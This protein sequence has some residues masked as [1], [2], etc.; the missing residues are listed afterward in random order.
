M[1]DGHIFHFPGGEILAGIAAWWFVS[2]SYY[3]Y[4]DKNHLNWRNVKTVESRRKAYNMSKIYHAYWLRE[5]LEMRNLDVHRNKGN[6]SSERIKVMAQKVL[7]VISKD[8]GESEMRVLYDKLCAG[9]AEPK[10]RR[11]G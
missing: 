7:D 4:I 3:L 1:K 10:A 8:N 5:V 6:L 2:Y 9:H 11:G